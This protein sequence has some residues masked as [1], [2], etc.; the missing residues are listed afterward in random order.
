M[1]Y[2]KLSVSKV[3]PINA[4]TGLIIELTETSKENYVSFWL[5]YKDSN[6]DWQYKSTKGA[7]SIRFPMTT[8]VASFIV[9]SL[10][11]VDEI[12]KKHVKADT[13]KVSTSKLTR[14]ELLALLAEL[15]DKK[16]ATPVKKSK[17]TE[18]VEI[19]FTSSLTSG[20]TKAQ[21]AKLLKALTER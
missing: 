7:T 3:F 6:N 4:T 19:D 16:P 18:E 9:S 1:E 11:S 14:S 21:K 15:E 5:Q 12:N 10:A 2:K 13:S 8:E 20:L 17:V